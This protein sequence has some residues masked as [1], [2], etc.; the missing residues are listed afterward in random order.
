MARGVPVVTSNGSALREISGDAA[1]LVDPTDVDDIAE[2]L[3]SVME[4]ESVE[5]LYSERGLAHYRNFPWSTTVGR[6]WAVYEE[7]L[8]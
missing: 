7:L 4:D 5:K 8:G 6:T 3:W 1:I 2:A